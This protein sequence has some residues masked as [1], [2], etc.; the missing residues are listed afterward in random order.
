MAFY[1]LVFSAGSLSLLSLDVLLVRLFF[2]P[3]ESGIYS[4]VS[5]LARMIFYGLI[6]FASLM[7][8]FVSRRF[9]ASLPTKTVLYK[10]LTVVILF[11]I[12]GVLIFD[13]FP[14]QVISILSGENYLAGAKILPLFSASLLFLSLSY[15]LL[16]YL[17]A[18]NK[19][20]STLVLAVFFIIQPILISLMHQSLYQVVVINLS[21]QVCLFVSL[22]IYYYTQTKDVI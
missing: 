14:V 21:I 17:I 15:I 13:N 12:F 19:N 3:I 6:P 18:I 10:I 4:A 22:L 16:S 8:P 9:A 7:L 5:V 2:T 11:G 1:S 20:K